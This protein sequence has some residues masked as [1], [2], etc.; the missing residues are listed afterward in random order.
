MGTTWKHGREPT[1]SIR[2]PVRMN[3]ALRYMA[4]KQGIPLHPRV[5][6]MEIL[7][8]SKP[9]VEAYLDVSGDPP[10]A[11]PERIRAAREA[12]SAVSNDL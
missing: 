11:E 6:L 12:R 3:T 2:L 10:R 1:S 5:P 8:A 7:W 9:F 4:L